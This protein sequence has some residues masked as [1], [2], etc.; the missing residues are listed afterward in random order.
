MGIIKKCSQVFSKA[1][2]PVTLR[3]LNFYIDRDPNSNFKWSE[4][5]TVLAGWAFDSDS[6][7]E[8]MLILD[9]VEILKFPSN[10]ARVDL[11]KI[12]TSNDK[13]V[14]ESGFY[15]EIPNRL[16]RGLQT[17]RLCVAVCSNGP[18][19]YKKIIWRWREIDG[20]QY[21][22]D[23]GESAQK[24][25]PYFTEDS[26]IGSENYAYRPNSLELQDYKKFDYV[27]EF[28]RHFIRS[29]SYVTPPES[30]FFNAKEEDRVGINLVLETSGNK[31]SLVRA[32][33]KTEELK[34]FCSSSSKFFI[35]SFVALYSEQ[36]KDK[37]KNGMSFV[38]FSRFIDDYSP[39]GPEI[40]FCCNANAFPSWARVSGTS[41]ED[42][43]KSLVLHL[44]DSFDSTYLSFPRLL[45][46]YANL[47]K[48]LVLSPFVYGSPLKGINLDC[49]PLSL[50]YAFLGTQVS[51]QSLNSI[52]YP[53]CLTPLTKHSG[54]Y[55][56][57]LS[58]L[59]WLDETPPSFVGGGVFEEFEV[60]QNKRVAT[61]FINSYSRYLQPPEG[62]FF[63][64]AD[65]RQPLFLNSNSE[66]F[67]YSELE[68]R[69]LKIAMEFASTQ[70]SL[71]V[72]VPKGLM[73]LLGLPFKGEKRIVFVLPSD[74]LRNDFDSGLLFQIATLARKLTEDSYHC[75]YVVDLENGSGCFVDG[76]RVMSLEEY[77]N[78]KLSNSW[79]IATSGQAM[80]AA[81][82][83]QYLGGG[84]IAFFIQ[85][86]EDKIFEVEKFDYAQ[87]FKWS[88]EGAYVPIINNATLRTELGDKVSNF[89]PLP[90]FVNN[91][92]FS[93]SSVNKRS[94]KI[95]VL[96]GTREFGVSASAS[97][98]RQFVNEI[99]TR[100]P[101]L[102]V[103]YLAYDK[104]L[105][106]QVM[107]E[108]GVSGELSVKPGSLE[109]AELFSSARLFVDL[110]CYHGTSLISAEALASGAIPLVRDLNAS[111][112]ILIHSKNSLCLGEMGQ[113]EFLN[114][115]SEIISN[116]SIYCSFVDEG[117]RALEAVSVDMATDFVGNMEAM[118][119]EVRFSLEQKRQAEK[120]EL[121]IILPVHGALDCFVQCIRALDKFI[122]EF[123]RVVVV[124]DC[125]D[126]YC[127][128]QINEICK[129]RQY[130][131]L[132]RLEKNVG[133]LQ[134]CIKGLESVSEDLDILLLN[135]DVIITENTIEKLRE[136]AYSRFDVALVSS[137][138]T[139]S[140][141][142]QINLN[143]GDSL[144]EAA[145]KIESFG[146]KKFPTVITP[147]GQLMY[148]RR[149]AIESYGFFD[150]TY[151]FGFCEESDMAMRMFLYG[152]DTVFA[153]NSLIHHRKSASFGKEKRNIHYYR[154]RPVFDQ[155]WKRYYKPLFKEFLRRDPLAELRKRYYSSFSK[156]N[157]IL[158]QMEITPEI[159]LEKVKK[160]NSI[161]KPKDL[162]DV[163]SFDVVFILPSIILGGGTLSVLQHANELEQRGHKVLLISLTEFQDNIYHWLRSPVA[164]SIED[165]LA[166]NWTNQRVVATFWLTAYLV[167]EI[168]KKSSDVKAFYYVQDYEPWF[169]SAV[170]QPDIVQA[171]KKTYD[172]G[173]H[174]IAKTPYLKKIVLEQENKHIDVISPGIDS[175]N[176]YPGQQDK[177]FG[178]I[179]LTA[180][181]RPRT[182]RRGG[183]EVLQ[184]IKE[185]K[186]RYAGIDIHL[187]GEDVE[188]DPLIDPYVTYHG[189][190][191]P[192][193]VAN[194]YRNSDIVIDLSHWHGFGRMGI[195]GM[196]CGTIP[197]LTP[198]GGISIYAENGKN[199]F[200]VQK[201]DIESVVDR[202]ILLA[203]NR[204][205]R[206]EMRQSAIESVARFSEYNASDDWSAILGLKADEYPFVRSSFLDEKII[207]LHRRANNS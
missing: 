172:M 184:F 1:F 144:E 206:M 180:Y 176:F 57:T 109:L 190:L 56:T 194:L 158:S 138:S 38:E 76:K 83:V 59:M 15:L 193:Q 143:Q 170:E 163:S 8:L 14:Q 94:N 179:R 127:A 89:V 166:L 61:D 18:N 103:V 35:N 49:D 154:N 3:G 68:K 140:P 123:A 45:Q 126:A 78:S 22:P 112:G 199:S 191:S 151:N 136:A 44:E 197:I 98:V 196:K 117:Q 207:R 157:K 113:E 118:Y 139:N 147:E 55:L 119:R 203:E 54:C 72:G 91:E 96:C 185:I 4:E 2:H 39:F 64:A 16:L 92:I 17:G 168:K 67:S 132:I 11:L 137:L 160:A 7:V 48:T 66:S 115:V 10:L 50:S 205:L 97:E 82:T 124:D 100:E 171:V 161:K 26:D 106:E 20:I 77:S 105:A 87:K 178:R 47:S 74:W 102:E 71:S 110:N 149:W 129:N 21:Y 125:S 104:H 13:G 148:I 135:S 60:I 155:R 25:I 128:K 111:N 62:L 24:Q 156:S 108:S 153:D 130:I 65:L 175:E 53:P 37:T 131:S 19:P 183:A 195:E 165:I 122:P 90:V 79:V 202:V 198:S 29:G 40:S 177:Y 145:R 86:S 162:L 150:P 81:R 146:Y 58:F 80:A 63:Y 188:I 181:Y 23:Y 52:K 41:I 204:Q 99:A 34:S 69:Y 107:L 134:A 169:Y 186:S 101:Y 6:D 85:N 133:F 114:S 173:F 187:F 121:A 31:S 141:N 27:D 70:S 12:F 9:G 164:L 189:M 142:L 200:I 182:V 73:S 152:A 32:L 159:V 51:E 93:L 75:E 42:S 88:L 36:S 46:D 120:R 84:K 167:D 192:S 95:V 174:M 5:Q 116:D 43:Q 28:K 33:K 201:G 30:C